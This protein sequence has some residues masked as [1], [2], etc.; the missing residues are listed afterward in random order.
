MAFQVDDVLAARNLAAS[1]SAFCEG[2]TD[3]SCVTAEA[4]SPLCCPCVPARSRVRAA[5]EIKLLKEFECEYQRRGEFE[6][7]FPAR[8]ADQYLV[9]QHAPAHAF[10][11]LRC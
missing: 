11:R 5:Q 3:F 6:L 9:R 8:N 2:L 1:T 10:T 4:S 7:M